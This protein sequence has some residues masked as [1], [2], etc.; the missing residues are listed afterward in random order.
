MRAPPAR[1]CAGYACLQT[2]LR[3]LRVLPHAYDLARSAAPHYKS[4]RRSLPALWR[5]VALL[6]CLSDNLPVLRI[7][8]TSEPLCAVDA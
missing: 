2:Q 8:G 1:F 7:V 4:P 5:C 6:P 3:V